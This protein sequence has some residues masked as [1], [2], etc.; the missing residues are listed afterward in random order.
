MLRLR[1]R[2]AKFSYYGLIYSLTVPQLAAANQQQSL[3]SDASVLLPGMATV[4]S[5]EA[6]PVYVP[7]SIPANATWPSMVTNLGWSSSEQQTALMETNQYTPDLLNADVTI[8]IGNDHTIT[9]A[10]S[11]FY[12]VLQALNQGGANYTYSD[13][14]TAISSLDD[15]LMQWGSVATLMPAV[16]AG[17]NLAQVSSQFNL[18]PPTLAVANAA[19]TNL[20]QAGQDVTIQQKTIRTRAGDTFATIA[21]NFQATYKLNV[22]VEAI[23]VAV[24]DNPNFL[25]GGVPL[26]LPPRTVDFSITL[27]D[28][29]PI[30]P[31]FTKTVFEVLT[32][33]NLSRPDNEIHGD[34]KDQEDV[35]RFA[36]GIPPYLQVD[37]EWRIPFKQVCPEFRENFPGAQ[38][39]CRPSARQP[40]KPDSATIQCQLHVSR[41]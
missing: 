34:F 16:P 6:N 28:S 12:S 3:K 7:Y 8:T 40:D 23:A 11:T 5:P 30:P 1:Q 20:I 14:I 31:P 2:R 35:K 27:Y 41:D 4:N 33:L 13:L 19:L 21:W 29:V 36:S 39:G 37:A 25:V 26:L 38:A 22:S 24:A 18:T 10:D 32:T 9:T 15:L 17:K